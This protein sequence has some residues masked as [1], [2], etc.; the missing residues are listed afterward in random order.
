MSIRDARLLG[1]FML[2]LAGGIGWRLHHADRGASGEAAHG[3][4]APSISETNPESRSFRNAT[5]VPHG[6]DAGE[7]PSRSDIAPSPA[8]WDQWLHDLTH[9]PHG[10]LLDECVSIFTRH[11]GEPQIDALA[12]LYTTSMDPILRQRVIDVFAALSSD[13]GLDAARRLMDAPGLGLDHPLVRA[14]AGALARRGAQSDVEDMLRRLDGLGNPDAGAGLLE[15][16]A[17]VKRPA[18]EWMLCQTAAGNGSSTTSAA[19][20]AAAAAL[21]NYPTVTVTETLH[22]IASG[23]ADESVKK[24]AE[25]SLAIIRTPE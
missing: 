22:A 10:A 24:Q 9:A 25:R 4:G 20:A 2:L 8:E 13:N 3:I 19:R 16:V 7:S 6:R 5:A 1:L 12:S 21:A 11:A 23:D 15:A 17:R 18:L 14:C